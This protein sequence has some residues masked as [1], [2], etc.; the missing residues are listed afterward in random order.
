MPR[1]ALTGKRLLFLLLLPAALL[2]AAARAA[3]LDELAEFPEGRDA[4]VRI[5]FSGPV[6]YLRHEVFGDA[7]VEIYFRPLTAEPTISTETRR[8]AGGPAFPGVEVVYPQQERSPTRKLTVRLTAP[9]KFRVRP[10]GNNAIDLVVPGAAARLA[11]SEPE[12]ARAAPPVAPPAKPPVVVPPKPTA[13]PAPPPPPARE[14]EAPRRF[15]LR[16]ATFR[17]I[18][19]MRRASPVP[20]EFANYEVQISEARRDGRKEYDLV[21]GYFGTEAAA[22]AARQRLLRRF[23]RTEVVDLGVPQ[24]TVAAAP[25]A[26]KPAAPAV[27]APKPAAEAPTAAAAPA[28]PVALPAPAPLAS[29]IAAPETETRAAE[30][31]ALARAALESGDTG[32]AIDRLNELLRL[33]PNRQSRDA[34][35]L[36]GIARERSGE[37]AKARAEYELY[38][39]LY[40]QAAGAARVRERLAALAAAPAVAAAARRPARKPTRTVTGGLSQYY[41]GGRSKIETAFDTPTTVDRATF[42][43]TDQSTLVTNFD[44]TLRNRS[45]DADSRFVLRDTDTHSY[46]DT[47]RSYNRLTAAYYDYRGQGNGLSARVGRQTGLSGGLPGR[48]DGAVAGYGIAPKWRVN[49]S[50]GVPVEYPEIETERQFWSTNLEYQNLD[51]AWSGNFYYIDQRADGLIDRRAV[52]TEVRYFRGGASLFSLLDYDTD[53]EE[54]N[55][56]MVQGTWQTEGGTTFNVLYDRR[57]APTLATTNAIFGQGT[58]SLDLLRQTFTE[59]QLRQQ[60]RDVT[61]TVTQA[62]VGF[63]T[64]VSKKW[65]V[66]ADLRLTNVGPLPA[67]VLNGLLVPAQPETGDIYNYNLQAIG[68]NLYSKRDTSV[69]SFNYLDGPTQTGVL[70]S[71]N[72]LSGLGDWTVEP[73]LKYYHQTDTQDVTLDRVTPSLRLSYQAGPRVTLESEMTWEISRTEG[74]SSREDS[75]RSYYYVGYRWNF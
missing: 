30:L 62:F 61:A 10:G 18:E 41:Y 8:L 23:P 21:L 32:P 75:T 60:A 52:G 70:V 27:E 34:Q 24:P 16:L 40:P 42:S 64:P 47:Q 51:D 35:E 63:T 12:V 69:F 26:P 13:P 58:T 28:A 56:T 72:N 6:Q 7:F 53:Y 33:P 39:K 4:V 1:R 71:Y 67:V 46:L 55:I 50:A 65:K 2:P 49:A 59:E 29:A 15:L 73:S 68:T 54:W 37:Y 66:G 31:V 48:F 44:I 45:A 36:M 3:V 74:P 43:A 57:K 25:P 20:A 11:P 38:L 9:L 19:E 17:S 22:R 5:T 14:A